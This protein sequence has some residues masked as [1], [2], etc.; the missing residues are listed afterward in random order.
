MQ[1]II[2]NDC[3]GINPVICDTRE[4]CDASCESEFF[5]SFF[6]RMKY[7]VIELFGEIWVCNHVYACRK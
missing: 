3:H 6:L 4:M 7:L 1:M 5:F 2:F